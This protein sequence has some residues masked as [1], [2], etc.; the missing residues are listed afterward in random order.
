MMNQ[1]DKI[2]IE[3]TKDDIAKGMRSN[4]CA[5]PIALAIKR[6]LHCSAVEVNY[7]DSF[8]SKNGDIYELILPNI[9]YEFIELFDDF[10][11]V[12]PFS[13]DLEM[14]PSS[15][16]FERAFPNWKDGGRY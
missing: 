7:G 15:I 10:A 3:V 9:A 8:I 2:K 1:N 11:I 4:G 13:F 5:C 6:T 12:E 16:S 14:L